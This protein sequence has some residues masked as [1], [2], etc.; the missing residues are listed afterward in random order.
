MSNFLRKFGGWLPI[1]IVF[2]AT[3]QKTVY[4]SN[5][6]STGNDQL[7]AS[8]ILYAKKPFNESRIRIAINDKSKE[9]YNSRIKKLARKIDSAGYLMPL[10][11]KIQFIY[12]FYAVPNE[13][14][15]APFQFFI[16]AIFI[17]DSN[18]LYTNLF[19]GRL[20]SLFFY[21][22][23]LLL[24]LYITVKYFDGNN[25]KISLLL[26]LLILSYSFENTL[27]SLQMH[28]YAIGV[29]GIFGI[30]ALYLLYLNN[31]LRNIKSS[32]IIMG[33]FCALFMLMQ[34][35]LILFSFAAVFSILYFSIKEKTPL[36]VLVKRFVFSGILFLLA[37]ILIFVFFLS[38]HTAHVAD[39]LIGNNPLLL[40]YWFP[41]YKIHGFIDGMTYTV[42][43]CFKN[44]FEVFRFMIIFLPLNSFGEKLFLI[45]FLI[46]FIAGIIKIFF[47]KDVYICQIKV[48]L[49]SCSII[50][51]VFVVSGRIA[52]TPDRHSL[53][54]LPFFA[55]GIFFGGIKIS[56]HFT[57]FPNQ[58]K[59]I[60]YFFIL[61][62]FILCVKSSNDFLN[63]R[64]EPILAF[65]VDEANVP[66]NSLI[67][68][69]D[70]LLWM[71]SSTKQVPV[72]YET[73]DKSRQG[74]VNK[75]LNKTIIPDKIYIIGSN[76]WDPE[77]F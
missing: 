43:F 50:W 60:S 37:F 3:L 31:Y 55:I 75:S 40:Q 26:G 12:P 76:V 45:F 25:H 14:T 73:S 61:F 36:R 65:G 34:Y 69:F 47:S 42:T 30:T 39:H 11:K 62:V 49:F 24:Y 28:S 63:K 68:S 44:L 32:Y 66:E 17:R 2:A 8:S 53:I 77:S 52:F 5:F 10:L 13:T 59:T 19:L 70:R 71:F 29:F 58:Q 15:Y 38:K 18:S 4:L 16:T 35:Q 1:L 51:I 27:F 7:V 46:L 9:T 23:A 21:F 56:E 41:A 6:I 48:F 22:S 54:L 74:W 20:P 64:T 72:Y 33:V 57:I 67:I